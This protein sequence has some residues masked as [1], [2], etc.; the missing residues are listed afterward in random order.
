M[1][2]GKRYIFQSNI[3]LLCHKSLSTFSLLK[4]PLLLLIP[5][6]S[7]RGGNTTQTSRVGPILQGQKR[8]QV[9]VI[10]VRALLHKSPIKEPVV[11]IASIL[12]VK[13]YVTIGAVCGGDA[14][15]T[16]CHLSL[17]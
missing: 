14:T 9:R 12:R 10:L 7:I 13:Y 8:A 3:L 6:L 4:F 5:D 15:M 16:D 11:G 2:S 17:I 1:K